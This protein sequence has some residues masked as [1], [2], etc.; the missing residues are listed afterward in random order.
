[1]RLAYFAVLFAA[2]GSEQMPSDV[3]SR[4]SSDLANVLQQSK[5]LPMPGME[6]LSFLSVTPAA[7]DPDATVKFLNEKVFTDSNFLGAGLYRLPPELACTSGDATCVAQIA[8]AEARIRVDD[9]QFFLQL[10]PN[11]DEPIAATLQSDELTVTVNLDNADAAM[12]AF[13]QALGETAPNAATGGQL[14]ADIKIKDA[15]AKI[16]LSIDRALG[17][18]IADRGAALDGDAALRFAAEPGSIALDH[19]GM[20]IALG[21]IMAHLPGEDLSIAPITATALT[22]QGVDTITGAFDLKVTSTLDPAPFIATHVALDG[23]LHASVTGLE[24][25]VGSLTLT[26]NPE[27]YGFLAIAGDCVTA[28]D[29]YDSV[30][31]T[32]YTEYSVA[33]CR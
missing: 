29:A 13:A 5:D 10:G 24:L 4:V 27:A 17:F 16:T 32:D 7:I 23:S 21:T 11:H 2:C 8:Q 19:D 9:D 20:D 12:I 33:A 25:L 26:T 3:R 22:A 6:L 18:A 1:M 15:G 14:T 28:S 30:S 31:L